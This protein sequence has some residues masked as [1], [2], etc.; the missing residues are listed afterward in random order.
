M[1]ILGEAH[2][3][4]EING[5]RTTHNCLIVKEMENDVLIGVDFLT[6]GGY[7]LDFA[8]T[9]PETNGPEPTWR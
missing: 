2:V 4:I 1:G 9:E 8:K 3:D 5:L 7:V 6:A